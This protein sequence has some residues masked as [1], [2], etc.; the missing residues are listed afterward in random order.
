[1]NALQSITVGKGLSGND[2]YIP[3]D[4][5]TSQSFTHKPDTELYPKDWEEGLTSDEF[6]AAARQILRKKFDD[7]NQI[8]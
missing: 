7:R 8:S 1:M 5:K 6:L 2:R 3:I 4:R